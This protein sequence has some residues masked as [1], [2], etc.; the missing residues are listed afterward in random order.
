MR[1]TG[2]TTYANKLADKQKQKVLVID[3]FDHPSYRAE[4]IPIESKELAEWAVTP[5]DT[6]KSQGLHKRRLFGGDIQANI[7]YAFTVCF[8]ALVIIE[9]AAKAFDSNIPRR[10]KAIVIDHR[11]RGLDVIM[12]FHSYADPAPYLCRGMWDVMITFRTEDNLDIAQT[13]FS[14]WHIIESEQRKLRNQTDR[15]LKTIIYRE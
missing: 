15:H 1:Q 12:M 7:Q 6:L 13:K 4:Y 8:D 2:K 3:T 14:K 9:D 11:N 10:L 5:I